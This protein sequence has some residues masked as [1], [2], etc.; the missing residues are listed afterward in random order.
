MTVQGAGSPPLRSCV[1]FDLT[2]LKEA[3]RDFLPPLLFGLRLW[4]SVCLALYIAFWLQIDNA[5]WAGTSAAIVCQPQ[6]GAS[7]RK[8]WFRM[9]GTCIGAAMI[10]LLTAL[11]PQER[12]LF[13]GCLALW[14]ALAALVATLLRNFASYAAALAG[15]TVAIIGGGLL[16]AT[17]GVDANAA[18]LLSVARA[19]EICIGIVS[20]GIVLAGTDLGDA[21]RR[22][23]AGLAELSS[24]I[25]SRFCATLVSA[26]PDFP[27][28]TPVRREFLRRVITL[29]PAVDLAF[30]ESSQ[31]RYHSPVL[32]K[33]VDGLST[34]LRDGGRS[35]TTWLGSPRLG[36]VPR[37]ASS[38]KA[39]RRSCA[40]RWMPPISRTGRQ[41]EVD[42]GFGTRGVVGARA[43]R[44]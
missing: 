1:N 18:F 2:R 36:P 22:L 35:P 19:S 34:A 5:Y 41:S 15:Y 29:D 37:L 28:T 12:A 27:D 26:G 23:T 9:I 44:S 43:V 14:I 30:G 31:L 20:A 21:R 11:F 25:A 42:P 32:Q 8:G 7:L 24:G 6:L 4:A 38:G 39:F 16:G 10:V 3:L 40:S 13:L 33:A 17:G